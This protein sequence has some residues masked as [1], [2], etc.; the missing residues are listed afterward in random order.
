MSTATLPT[1]RSDARFETSAAVAETEATTAKLSNT[2]QQNASQLHTAAVDAAH[3]AQVRLWFTT[4]LFFFL[5]TNFLNRVQ[6]KEP[7][8]SSAVE[9]LEQGLS[10]TTDVAA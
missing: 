10:H 7:R 9:E 3:S 2:V 5:G 1:G 6:T 8:S 4:G